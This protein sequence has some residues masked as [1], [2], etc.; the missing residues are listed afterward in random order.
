MNLLS[1]LVFIQFS[2]V[3]MGEDIARLTQ[4]K[5][6]VNINKY[7]K[8]SGKTHFLASELKLLHENSTTEFGR[9]NDA[10]ENERKPIQSNLTKQYHKFLGCGLI[11]IA[12]ITTWQSFHST[13]NSNTKVFANLAALSSL[14]F[15][16]FSINSLNKVINLESKEKKI[17]IKMFK[18]VT[19]QEVFNEAQFQALDKTSKGMSLADVM[20]LQD[21]TQLTYV[22][23]EL[24]EKVPTK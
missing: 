10:Y 8:K 13:S 24:D 15:G 14:V 7:F 18:N 16:A 17:A 19:K 3:G 22:P 9:I 6:K 4:R 12:G 23:Y 21:D 2:A 11:A 5:T 20:T 1:A